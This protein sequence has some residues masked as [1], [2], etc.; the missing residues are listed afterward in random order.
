MDVMS[1]LQWEDQI[2]V[3]FEVALNTNIWY[4]FLSLAH[5]INS[6]Q[7]WVFLI[8]LFL[9]SSSMVR[10]EMEFDNSKD[11]GEGCAVNSSKSS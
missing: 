3:R 8:D 5:F 4:S 2:G 7:L 10:V 9:L 11:S 6:L 1:I